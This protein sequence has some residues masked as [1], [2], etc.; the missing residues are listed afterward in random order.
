MLRGLAG[1]LAANPGVRVL[2][3]LCL[4]LLADFGAG[5]D[6]VFAPLLAAGLVPHLLAREGAAEAVSEDAAWAA[7]RRAG[8]VNCLFARPGAA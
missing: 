2:C 5:P 3:E 4:A 7:A 1:T 8:Y 6:D